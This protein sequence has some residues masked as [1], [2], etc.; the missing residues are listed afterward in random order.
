MRDMAKARKRRATVFRMFFNACST[1]EEYGM[2]TEKRNSR[3][4]NRKK[5]WKVTLLLTLLLSLPTFCMLIGVLFFVATLN[6]L[7]FFNIRIYS[8]G[9]QVINYKL[10]LFRESNPPAFSLKESQEVH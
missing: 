4:V 7:G 6:L 9:F 1:S 10:I 2:E 5:D 8:V 3:K